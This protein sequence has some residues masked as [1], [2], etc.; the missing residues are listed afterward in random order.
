MIT[1]EPHLGLHCTQTFSIG[2]FAFGS[3]ATLTFETTVQDLPSV[4]KLSIDLNVTSFSCC[5]GV[6]TPVGVSPLWL[7][8]PPWMSPPPR[9]RA[10]RQQRSIYL[11]AFVAKS[12]VVLFAIYRFEL[13]K[14]FIQTRSRK[15]WRKWCLSEVQWCVHFHFWPSSTTRPIYVWR[16]YLYNFFFFF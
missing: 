6:T 3:Y 8:T 5:A 4:L 7:V 9:A 11:C 13:M 2:L 16:K 15:K 10:W 12:L 14:L 1:L